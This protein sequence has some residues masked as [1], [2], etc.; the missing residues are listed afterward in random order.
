MRLLNLIA[1]SEGLTL[2]GEDKEILGLTADS[3]KVERGFLFVAIPGTQHDG[4]AYIKDAIERG[5]AALLV[6]EGTNVSPLSNNIAV[7]K[8]QDL[9]I[10]LAT[11]AAT[12]YPHQPKIIAAVTGTSGK[13]ST[14][15]FTREIWTKLGHKSASMGSLGFILP[16]EARYSA[17]NTPET[18]RLH[19]QLEEAVT[20]GISHLV[21]E[22]SSHGLALHRMDQVRVGIGAFTNLSRDHLDFH[23]DMNEYFAA[24]LRLFTEILSPTGV[25]VV[26]ADILEFEAL[27]RHL[28][29]RSIKTLTYGKAGKDIKLHSLQ[30]HERGQI[31]KFELFGKAHEIQLPIIGKFQAWNSLCALGIVVGSGD[32]PLTAV[33]AMNHVSGVTGRLELTGYTPSGGAIFV[34]YA[35]KPDALENVLAALRPHVEAHKG[36]KLGVIFGCGGNRDKGKRP[37]MG[38]IAQRLADWVIVTD[39]NPRH[40][41]AA[42]IRRDVLAGCKPGTDLREIS[43][44]ASAIKIGIERLRQGDVLIIAGKGHESGQIIGD[45]ILPFDDAEVAR[46]V[47]SEAV[48]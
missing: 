21:M 16:D 47:L 48:A 46:H 1:S 9:R 45:E 10:A 5:A 19:Q 13:T 37:L 2:Q 14:T 32:D 36:A 29:D 17:L 31:V 22:A 34:D 40:E 41:D 42:A 3:R 6:P 25:A 39:D 4:R 26:N 23:S 28:K 30:P 33:A 35:H 12:F 43:D 38:Q 20:K 44:R 15:Q 24:K 7:L 11:I 27:A 18:I 8:A